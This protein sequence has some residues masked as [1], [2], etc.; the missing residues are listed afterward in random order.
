M[1]ETHAVAVAGGATLTL[2]NCE[3]YA[4]SDAGALAFQVF[5][6]GGTI[7]VN[8]TTYTGGYGTTGKMKSGCVAII[9]I[10]GIEVYRKG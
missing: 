8:N 2:N 4:G 7:N 3:V 6:S 9:N 5:S 10:D 1:N